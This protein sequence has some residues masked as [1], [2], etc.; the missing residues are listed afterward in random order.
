M[1][2]NCSSPAQLPE[3]VSDL[4]RPRLFIH[5]HS[6]TLCSSIVGNIIARRLKSHGVIFNRLLPIAQE[7][8]LERDAA[9][10]GQKVPQH[11]CPVLDT[12]KFLVLRKANAT[13]Q[14]DC[15]QWIME[16]SPK[17]AP[18]TPQRVVHEL[19][20]IWFGSVH[21]VSTTVTFAIHDLC[22]HPE[23]VEPLRAECEAQY[24]DFER[25]G[26]GLPL[27]DS[28]IKESARLTP[29]ESRKSLLHCYRMCAILTWNAQ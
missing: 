28:F 20:A 16:T 17:N 21:A 23:Y 29:V 12:A 14:A 26:T 27:L 3:P 6:I 7:R 10:L 24:D 5:I 4:Y 1:R 8:C 19:M 18:W 9:K 25:T 2:R 13:V 15:I 22:L 11:V